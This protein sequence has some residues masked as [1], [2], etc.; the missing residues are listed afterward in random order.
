MNI[1]KVK[2][3]IKFDVEKS[4]QNKW[5]VLLNIVM[6]IGILIATNWSNVSKFLEEHNVTIF[7]A[8]K[9]TIEVLDQEN[10]FYDDLVKKFEENKNIEIKKVDENPYSKENIPGDDLVLVEVKKDETSVISAKMVSKEGIDGELYDLIYEVLKETR[11][12]VFAENK[13]ITLE[14]LNILNE[15]VKLE[16]QLLGVDSENSDTKEIIKVISIVVVYMVLIFVLSRIANEIAQEK[17]SKSIE[18]VLTSVSEKEYLLAKVLSSTITILIQVLYTFV[19]YIIGNMLSNLASMK[20]ATS[21]G[22]IALMGTVDSSIVG[23]VLAMCAYLV[24]T[25]FLTTLIQAALSAKTTSVAEAGNTT[26]LLMTAIIVLYFLSIAVITPY[27]KVSSF[28]YIISCLPLVSTFFVPAMMIIGQATTFQIIISFVVLIITVPL[29]FN[30]CAKHFKNGILDYSSSNK[31]KLFGRKEKKELNLKEKQDYELRIA[32]AKKFSFTIGM[33][34]II[35]IFLETVGSFICSIALPSLFKEKLEL[36]TILVLEN[37]ITLICALAITSGFVKF[38]SDKVEEK[39][40]KVVSGKEKFEIVFM[41]IALLAGIQL[42][43]TW[44]YPKIGLDYNI[45]ET[46]SITPSTSILSKI[47]YVLGMALVP[48]I[49]EELL[50]R[51]EILNSCKRYGKVFAVVFSSIL[52]GLYHF[53]LNQGIFAFLVGIIFGIIAIKT[54]S[55]KLTVLL[56]FLNNGYACVQEILGAGTVAFEIFNN[57][58][59]A[60]IIVG[61][62]ILLKNLP[63]LKN[64]KK[65]DFK[66]NKDC[67]YLIRNYTFIVAMLLLVVMFVT[68]ENLLKI[69]I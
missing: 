25:V 29:I 21:E 8:D 40:K 36:S 20:T 55:I 53:N 60:I 68:T 50:F 18:Y 4:I 38:Y 22:A 16:R 46:F 26:M 32:K 57:V 52:F 2:E 11:S 7:E 63:K 9:V 10:L 66:L 34:M 39:E 43:I 41:G 30:I 13:G 64:L 61:A 14:E 5:F 44:L 37:S 15:E 28:M 45:F 51:K 35:L 54:N 1:R 12:K 19:Y 56:H 59:I 31:K 17:V 27:T 42:F 62:L 48:A 49:F 67:K 23:Y 24:F 33:A 58:I 3:I 65:E 6:F 47:L 69:N